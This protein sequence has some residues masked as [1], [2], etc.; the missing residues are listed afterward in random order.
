MFKNM[1]LLITGGTGTF[2]N[3]VLQA[4]LDT[5]IKEIRIFSRNEKKQDERTEDGG[6]R[7]EGGGHPGEMRSAVVNEFHW[8]GRS[9]KNNTGMLE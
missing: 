5:G 8:A 1:T 6:R 2:S 7:T 9:G 4:F 3:A